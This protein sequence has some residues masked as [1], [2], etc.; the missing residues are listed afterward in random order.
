[1][2]IDRPTNS[3][4]TMFPTENATDYLYNVDTGVTV[5]LIK[6]CRTPLSKHHHRKNRLSFDSIDIFKKR[7]GIFFGF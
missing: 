1:M 2:I 5:T 7:A 3:A 6:P 4:L